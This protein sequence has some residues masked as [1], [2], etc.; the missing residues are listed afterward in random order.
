MDAIST[1]LNCKV[2]AVVGAS[3][4]EQKPG[5]YV[6]L[7]LIARGREIIPVNPKEAETFGKNCFPSLSSLPAELGKRV[8]LVEVFRRP[9]FI[10][11]LA[12]EI[13]GLKTKFPKLLGVWLQE[14]IRHPEAEK[15][16][17]AAGLL[18]VSGKC[19]KKELEKAR[20]EAI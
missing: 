5:H 10:P 3:A 19:L 20:A 18:V 14:G 1:L 11:E 13:I 4:D 16:L 17:R 2:I 15:K 12:D 7:F 6:P 8:E 9:E